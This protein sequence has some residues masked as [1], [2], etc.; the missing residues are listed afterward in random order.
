MGKGDKFRPTK[1]NEYRENFDQ[2]NWK[3]NK[4]VT[5]DKES[6]QEKEKEP[7]SSN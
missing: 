3:D 7:E 4:N 2:I 5:K 6:I 1:L